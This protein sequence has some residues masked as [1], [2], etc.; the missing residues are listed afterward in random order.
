MDPPWVDD[1]TE[2]NEGASDP[3]ANLV[4]VPRTLLSA[5]LLAAAVLVDGA[6]GRS[7][8][9]Y[10]VLA[11][12]PAVAVSALSFFGDLVEGSADDEAG[13]LYVGLTSLALVL[14]VIGAAVR[15]NA[16]RDAALPALG[17]SA[18]VGALALIGLQLTVWASLRFT[19]E[20]LVSVL[21]S[22]ASDV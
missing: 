11:A 15:A 10:L 21:H 22:H 5:V 20:R 2:R 16:L 9:L 13:A 14:L 1:G 12:I 3:A 8:A 19:R 4:A 18:V 17:T 6:G 7:L